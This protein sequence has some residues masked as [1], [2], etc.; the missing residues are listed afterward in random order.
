[1][2]SEA[3][4]ADI[5]RRVKRIAAILAAALIALIALTALA[6]VKRVK[7][8]ALALAALTG[9]AAVFG[10]GFYLIP[11]LR[12][13][14]FLR[15]MREGLAREME[16]TIVSIADAPETHDGARV[17]PVRLLLTDA[18]DER[19]IYLNASRRDLFPEPGTRVKV[20]LFGRH[21]REVETEN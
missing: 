15:D 8:A 19:I 20:R 18:Q 21:I 6:L 9:A 17:L 7:V 11:C 14:A 13:R 16:G 2:Y 3:D 4:R 10:V 5:D 1:M 12:Y